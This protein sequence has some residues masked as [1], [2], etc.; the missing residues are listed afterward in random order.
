M[1]ITRKNLPHSSVEL[2]VE[3]DQ[4]K[5]VEFFARAY[6]RLAPTVTIKGFRPGAAPKTMV[7]ERIGI[8]RYTQ[9]A[10]NVAIIDTYYHAVH[11]EKIVPL[12]QP[13]VNIREYG[14]ESPLVYDATVDV[15]P[16]V[17]LGDYTKLKVKLPSESADA[18][19]KEV[20]TVLKRVRLQAATF[21]DADRPAAKGDR[22]E[23]NFTGKVKGV[24]QDS[25]TSQHYP[26]ILGETPLIPGFEDELIGLKK[27]D[28][29]SFKL[30]VNPTSPSGLRGASKEKVDFDV[31][32]LDVQVVTLPEVNAEFTKNFGHDSVDALTDAL[33]KGIQ[34]EKED[35]LRHDR[36]EVI[37][38]ALIKQTKLDLPQSLIDQELT[39][40]MQS[41]QQQFGPG[42]ERFLK[43]RYEDSIDKFRESLK[44]DA[45]RS[46]AAGLILGEVA[47]R[48]KLVPN[49]GAKTP[50][51][52]SGVMKATLDRLIS[53]VDGKK[54]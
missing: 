27:G 18:T 11:Q 29:K 19:E 3:V 21:A 25:L 54:D 39:R 37:L 35:R 15:L 16:T 34:G 47:Q 53:F 8:D 50:E 43:E 22:V 5:M 36:E 4:S 6:E 1:K 12:T 48:E 28:E 49:G 32:C 14:A 9:E 41:I 31:E 33:K 52:Q 24:V 45:E 44:G 20:E 13:A 42:F 26:M 2:H 30:T 7:L 23:L 10:I 38:E 17:E 46:V 51:E 40:R